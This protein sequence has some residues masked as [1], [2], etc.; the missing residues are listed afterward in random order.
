MYVGGFYAMWTQL[1]AIRCEFNILNTCIIYLFFT[2]RGKTY[3]KVPQSPASSHADKIY[4]AE[5]TFD[6]FV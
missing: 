6:C 5:Q 4:V 1:I 2:L 3:G